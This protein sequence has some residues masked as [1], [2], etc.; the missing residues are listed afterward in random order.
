MTLLKSFSGAEVAALSTYGEGG[1]D[2]ADRG[3]PSSLEGDDLTL[4]FRLAKP[5]L[6]I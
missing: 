5:S 2:S 6:Y 3:L 1:T 4:P